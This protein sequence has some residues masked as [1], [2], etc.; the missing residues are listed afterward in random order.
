MVIF[1]QPAQTLVTAD[2]TGLIAGI[3]LLL[4]IAFGNVLQYTS[5]KALHKGIIGS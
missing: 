3:A 4:L 1:Q 2:V 5:W